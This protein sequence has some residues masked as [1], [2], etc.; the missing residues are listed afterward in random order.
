ME[1]LKLKDKILFWLLEK[2]G[3]TKEYSKQEMCMRA[4]LTCNRNCETCAW[5]WSE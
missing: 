4:M 3:F 1:E 5:N 2:F